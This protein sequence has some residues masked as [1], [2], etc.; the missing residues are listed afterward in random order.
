MKHC[1]KVLLIVGCSFLMSGCS[2]FQST[3]Q[4]IASQE[5]REQR[6]KEKSEKERQELIQSKKV[7]G[8][9]S[10]HEDYSSEDSTYVI[11]TVIT[12]KATKGKITKI[13]YK[14]TSSLMDLLLREKEI[15][16]HYVN[17]I[18]KNGY[19][20]K[21]KEGITE[22]YD[23][24]IDKKTEKATLTIDVNKA[25][26]SDVKEIN[27]DMFK[28]EKYDSWDDATYDD[29]YQSYVQERTVKESFK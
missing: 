12:V 28:L 7:V 8:S 25:K 10:K 11:D 13:E 2:M 9:F 23:M 14:Q 1:T 20:S 17:D 4:Q 21:N 6:E 16:E 19:F 26:I 27:G 18:K 3:Q 5:K 29:L 24:D 22:T 15:R